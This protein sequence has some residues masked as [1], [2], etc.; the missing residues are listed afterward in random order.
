MTNSPIISIDCETTGVNVTSDRILTFAVHKRWPANVQN[1]NEWKFNPGRPIP[2]DAT[3]VHGITDA[4]VSGEPPFTPARAA[5]II[6]FIG[7]DGVLIGF[8][9]LKF[10]IPIFLSELERC[11][12]KASFPPAGMMVIDCLGIYR[13]Q[14]PRDLASAVKLYAGR[15]HTEA[16]DSLADAEATADVLSGQLRQH[17]ELAAMT[18]Q[19]LAK[20]FQPDGMV[21]FSGKLFRDAAGDVCYGIGKDYGKKV[22]QN[23]GFGQWMLGKDFPSDTKDWLRREFEGDEL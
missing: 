5:K 8:N 17:A 20:Y 7:K 23:P 11:G 16:H 3:K 1:G 14:H 10:D 21:D 2:P 9:L 12:C 6:E 15:D 18:L 4:D 13:K 19:E 22:R